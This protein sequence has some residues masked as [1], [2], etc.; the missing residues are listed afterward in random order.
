[1]SQTYYAILTAVGEAKLANAA[2]LGT[3]LQLTHMAVGDG[4]GS[5][6]Q[7]SRTQT[8]LVHE[9]RRGPLNSL[10]IDP[11]NA[12]QIVAEH[13][14]P[15]DIGGWWIREIGLY[16]TA[17]DLCAV[18]N[19]P[20]TYKPV[21]AS[22]SGRIQTIRMVLIVSNTGAV[23]LKID[24]AIVLAPRGYVDKAMADHLAAPD[25]HPQYMTSSEVAAAISGKFDKAGG[26]IDGPVRLKGQVPD[27]LL[28]ESDRPGSEGLWHL[29]ADGGNLYIRRNTSPNRDFSTETYPITITKDDVVSFVKAAVGPTPAP[30]ANDGQY[31]TTEFVKAALAALVAS[32]PAALDTL[33]ELAAALGNDPNFATTMTN[34]LAGKAPK[35]TTLAGYGIVDGATKTD[36]NHAAP[37][38]AVAFFAMSAEPV[39]WLRA[40]G[41]IVSRTIYSALF[42]AIGTRFGAGDG[43]TTFKLPDL[44]GEFVRGWDYGGGVDSSDGTRELGSLQK[45]TAIANYTHSDSTI[46]GASTGIQSPIAFPDGAGPALATANAAYYLSAV[47]ASN[48]GVGYSGMSNV[49]PHNIALL[50]CIKF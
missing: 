17:G 6:P 36:V 22:G 14:I 3:A 45:A 33:N 34:A 47:S 35:A 26:A 1:M 8:A 27:L 9:N 16:D 39:G 38:G 31:A 25:P 48:G 28:D 30:S 32:S 18:A 11:A 10:F 29:L 37:A 42:A 50:A 44:R 15:E 20:D 12:S 13:I 46:V 19:C 21:L 2:A 43:A 4:N 49:R 7:P 24:P 5:T 40:D 23:Q 41:A